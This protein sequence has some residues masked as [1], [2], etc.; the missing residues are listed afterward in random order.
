MD[1]SIVAWVR[2]MPSLTNAN[3]QI[4]STEREE[5]VPEERCEMWEVMM[6][7]ERQAHGHRVLLLCFAQPRRATMTR[8]VRIAMVCT[9]PS[10]ISTV[11]DVPLPA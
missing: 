1:D 3:G 7:R 8:M 4:A 2:I 9:T 5:V 6:C 11:D 10:A